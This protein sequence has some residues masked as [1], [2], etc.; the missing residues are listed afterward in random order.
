MSGTREH[1]RQRH[2]MRT[3]ATMCA[4][5]ALA[6]CGSTVEVRTLAAPEAAALGGRQTFRVVE[7]GRDSLGDI[8]RDGDGYGI[9]DPMIHNSITARLVH[10]EIRAAFEALGYRYS[11]DRADFDVAFRATIAP[12]MDI[13]GYGYGGPS[14]YGYH[15]ND[16]YPISYDGWGCCGGAYAVATYDRSTVII[17]AIDPRGTLLW[18]GQGTSDWYADPKEFVKDLRRAVHAVAKAFPR[19]NGAL[20]VAAER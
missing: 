7:S 18:R 5:A 16:G 4:I 10:D 14:R 17:D 6:A 9:N 8:S 3:A 12:I 1:E 20:T 2:R 11:N 15:L 13:R 19:F